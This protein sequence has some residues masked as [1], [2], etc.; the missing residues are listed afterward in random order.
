MG[1][2]FVIED[3]V[4]RAGIYYVPETAV[5]MSECETQIIF[6]P[7]LMGPDGMVRRSFAT[8]VPD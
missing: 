4:E 7:E 8:A 1:S 6:R 5:H 3:V 2:R